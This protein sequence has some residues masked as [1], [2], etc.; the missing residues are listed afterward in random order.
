M[1]IAFPALILFLIALPGVLLRY[2]YSR[3]LWRSPR[4]LGRATE[5]VVYGMTLAIFLH[6]LWIA[7]SDMLGMK[8]DLEAV[9][10]FMSGS[11]GYQ[12]EFNKNAALIANSLYAILGYFGTL[13]VFSVVAGFATHGLVRSS[14]AD[15][16]FKWL[17]FKNPWYYLLTAEITEFLGHGVSR[18]IDG[19]VICAII[20]LDGE[21][22]LYRGLVRDFYYDRHGDLD[23]II[24]QMPHR[25]R[26]DADQHREKQETAD[27]EDFK[28]S[29]ERFY[30]IKGDFFVIKYQNIVTLN[31][32]YIKLAS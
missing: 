25:R 19:V 1:N 18:Q 24:L 15:R 17:R 21:N 27:C 6:G 7:L 20:K 30:R 32:E 4:S 28:A 13:F 5:E 8:V 9:V 31:V 29:D 16:K 2:T 14:K 12:Q 11:Y 3:G 22:Y 10:Y 23:R 26:L